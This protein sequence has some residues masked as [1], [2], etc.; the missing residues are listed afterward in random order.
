MNTQNIS[1]RFL[2]V[3]L[4]VTLILIGCDRSEKPT[5][6]KQVTKT[7]KP[8]TKPKQ[9][10][11]KPKQQTTKPKQQAVNCNYEWLTIV[12]EREIISR[13]YRKVNNKAKFVFLG[14]EIPTYITRYD[15]NLCEI[16]KQEWEMVADEN[17]VLALFAY[18]TI[19]RI[20]F[21][22]K[23]PA[24]ATIFFVKSNEAIFVDGVASGVI[25]MLTDIETRAYQRADK[26]LA[27][28]NRIYIQEY[29]KLD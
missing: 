3:L 28:S 24:V 21:F 10:T 22:V 20:E 5:K 25:S 18:D 9:Q 15:S 4:F 13:E 2:F 17:R 11:T 27:K 6:S 16:V 23:W 8:I 1:Y 7:E 14:R 19:N 26:A 29:S 12:R